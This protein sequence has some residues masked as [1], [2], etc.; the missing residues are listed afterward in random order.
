MAPR[1]SRPRRR[2]PRRCRTFEH[3]EVRLDPNDACLRP[4]GTAWGAGSRAPP[5]PSTRPAAPRRRS[6]RSRPLPGPRAANR[7]SARRSPSSTRPARRR[8]SLR[9]THVRVEGSPGRRRRRPTRGRLRPFLENVRS[10][11][12]PRRV[13]LAGDRDARVGARDLEAASTRVPNA[14]SDRETLDA[15][16]SPG[17]RRAESQ[18]GASRSTPS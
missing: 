9:S 3:L 17:S 4:A 15:N 1:A 2:G 7:R 10:T 12:T 8:P 5:S 14:R 6:T 13:T 18:R 11:G 16:V